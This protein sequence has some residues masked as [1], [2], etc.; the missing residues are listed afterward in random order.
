MEEYAG[1]IMSL[2]AFFYLGSI[3]LFPYTCEQTSR[4]FLFLVSMFGFAVS[5][6]C[7][8]PSEILGFPDS[9][10]LI[11]TS[12]PL[13]GIFMMCITIPVIPEMLERLQVDLQISEG[14]NEEV[15]LALNDKVNEALALLGALAQVISVL[16]GGFMYESIGPDKT[17]DY[18][19]FFNIGFGIILFIFNC[20]FFVFKEDREFK[21]KLAA[22]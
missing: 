10:W 15:D 2:P 8:G 13:M 3:L 7:L 22:L 20:G 14:L 17:C 21:I 6:F 1:L 5:I 11:A 16:A 12:Q 9:V 18:I 4:K 19:A